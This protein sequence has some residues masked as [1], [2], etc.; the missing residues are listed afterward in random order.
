M[1]LRTDLLAVLGIVLAGSA[2]QVMAGQKL[3]E[4]ADPLYPSAFGCANLHED[5]QTP[6]VEGRDGVF[7]RVYADLRM[8]HPFSDTTVGLL[9]QLSEA[10]AAQGTTLVFLPIPTKSQAMPDRMPEVA[11]HYGYKPDVSAAVYQD[12]I[13]R[14]RGAGVVAVHGQNAM[15]AAEPG[16]LPYFQADFHWTSEGARLAA[17]EVA[18]EISKLP[19]FST[20]ELSEF[21][22]ET[23]GEE[24]AFS[25]LRQLIQRNCLYKVPEPVTRTWK[26]EK[27]EIDLGLDLGG[28]G[29]G[30]IDLFGDDESRVHMAVIGTSFADMRISNFDGWLSQYSG[31]DVVNYAITGGNQ[32]G[33]ALSYLTSEDFRR[34]RPHFLVWENPIYNN[35]LQYGDQP[36]RELIAAVSNDCTEVPGVERT[37]PETLVLHLGEQGLTGS[38]VLMADAGREGP[39]AAEF[40]FAFNDG[41]E[42]A[43]HLER[44][45]RLRATGRFYVPVDAY[46]TARLET[47][48]VTFDRDVADVAQLKICS[49]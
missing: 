32:F 47:V 18:R 25:G 35:L 3:S 24:V 20:L 31:L 1:P 46:D 6:V 49:N 7:Y 38:E 37:S 48:S 29:S 21:T 13:D 26:T 8:H 16:Q 23:T 4:A 39:A 28:D 15:L 30:G 43:Q 45:K 12:I 2:S 34:D 27:A 44:G 33:A 5:S 14:L 40:R 11:R 17:A 9:A 10:L 41:R 42:R 22:T 36:L 19:E